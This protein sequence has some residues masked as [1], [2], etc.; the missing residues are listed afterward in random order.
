MRPAPVNVMRMEPDDL[1]AQR[2]D[3]PVKQL[4]RQDIDHLSIDELEARIAAIQAE[5]ERC[6]MK[7]QK[8]VNHRATAESL[9]KR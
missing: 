2:P 8:A 3:D 1:F 9:F 7:I 6:R 5:V 4:A